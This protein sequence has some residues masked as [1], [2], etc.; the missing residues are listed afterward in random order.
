LERTETAESFQRGQRLCGIVSEGWRPLISISEVRTLVN[1][2]AAEI[3]SGVDRDDEG[4]IETRRL[5]G[6]E[7]QSNAF[8]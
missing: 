4:H 5:A 6:R 3:V 1:I 7:M 8:I 2:T